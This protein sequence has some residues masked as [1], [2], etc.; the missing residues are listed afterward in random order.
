MN[1]INYIL[2]VLFLLVSTALMHKVFSSDSFP[3][4]RP[5]VPSIG[6]FYNNLAHFIC[7]ILSFLVPKDYPCQ[8]TSSIVS[9]ITS[10]NLSRKFLVSYDVTILFT[11]IAL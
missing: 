7:N 11:N 9:E 4:L 6:T 2:L 3:K 10:A 1:I 5:V 8:G